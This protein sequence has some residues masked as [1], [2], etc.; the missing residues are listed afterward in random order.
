[1]TQLDT[2]YL[3]TYTII[4]LSSLIKLKGR[5]DTMFIKY[6]PSLGTI[7]NLHVPPRP[8]HFAYLIGEI[9]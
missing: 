1:M 5:T 6:G 4:M 9:F 7:L 8:T 2:T 3:N